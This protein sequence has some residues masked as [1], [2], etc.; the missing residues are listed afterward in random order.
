MENNMIMVK[1]ESNFTIVVNMPDLPLHRTWKKRGAQ[2][3]I[4]RKQLLQA[5][6]DPSVEYLFRNG[7]LTTNDVDFLKEVGLME[8]VGTP[9][10]TL[11]TEALMTRLIKTMP[12]QQVRTELGKFSHDQLEE[13]AD[14]AIEH[15]TELAFDR[16][17]LLSKASGKNIMAAIEHH[18]KAQEA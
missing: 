14:F 18:R 3:P 2:Y 13:L 9:N 11:L 10:V 16:V 17:D 4:D 15:Y 1:S 8:E 5:F 6:Y 12:V 7:L